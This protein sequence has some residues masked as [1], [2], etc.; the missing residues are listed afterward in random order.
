MSYADDAFILGPV[1]LVEA[2]RAAQVRLER[3]VR[4]LAPQLAARL[5]PWMQGLAPGGKAEAYFLHPEAFPS[6][7]LPWIFETSVTKNN[8]DQFGFDLVYSTIAGYYSIRLIDNVM[9][10]EATDEAI[11]LPA[12]A[13]L[14]EEFAR[15]Y[16]DVFP[17]GDVF[18]DFFDSHWALS[19]EAA[20][21][22]GGMT[23]IDR[24]AFE[25]ISARKVL[26]A[27]IPM[28]AI[29]RRTLGGPTPTDWDELIRLLSLFHQMRNDLLDW[30]R[31]EERGASTYFLSQ[32]RNFAGLGEPVALWLAREGFDWGVDLLRQW[33]DEARDIAGRLGVPDIEAY[34]ARRSRDLTKAVASIRPGLAMIAAVAA[35]GP[36]A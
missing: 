34:L 25:T 17:T 28:S 12:S 2:T 26:A 6:L 36:E 27:R 35:V 22:D 1:G 30:R 21:E 13:F 20:I 32:A 24:T 5:T 10:R 3:R 7:L 4:S 23:E 16:H 11:L 29:A 15:H 8:P 14:H 33:L 9:D 18:W 31:D 19:A